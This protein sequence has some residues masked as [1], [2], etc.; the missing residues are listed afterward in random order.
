MLSLCITHRNLFV[1]GIYLTNEILNHMPHLHTFIFDIATEHVMFNG[2]FKPYPDDIRC[3]FI[4]RG[5]DV[6]CYIDY[7]LAGSGRCHVY[8][9]QFNMGRIYPITHSFPGGMFVNVRNLR[10]RDLYHS[11]EH[12]FFVQ[13]SHSFPL[14]IRLSLYNTNEQKE[15]YHDS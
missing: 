15:N 3:S 6:D 9:L 7:D 1:D 10:M 11:F 2:Q 4:K 13:I 5:H 8:S 12:G 14:L